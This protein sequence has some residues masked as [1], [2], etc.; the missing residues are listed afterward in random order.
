[1]MPIKTDT[2]VAYSA[3]ERC[4]MDWQIP[5]REWRQFAGHPTCCGRQLQWVVLDAP[6]PGVRVERLY[7]DSPRF[8]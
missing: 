6:L 1:M 3:C 4:G 8:S 5:L 2:R 7:G